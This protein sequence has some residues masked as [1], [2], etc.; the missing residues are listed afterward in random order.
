MIAGR[1]SKF[2]QEVCLVEQP[3]VMDDSKKVGSNNLGNNVE[4]VA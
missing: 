2:Y 3:F 1:M 4:T